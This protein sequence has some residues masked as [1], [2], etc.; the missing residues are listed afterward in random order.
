MK[1]EVLETK[2]N[3]DGGYIALLELVVCETTED[4]WLPHW[5][6]PNDHEFEDI[7]IIF[8]HDLIYY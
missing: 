5:G 3:A 2:I 6:G 7:V 1:N 4:G 8:L